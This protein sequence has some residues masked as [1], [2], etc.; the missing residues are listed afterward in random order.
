MKVVL[1]KLM[2]VIVAIVAF[3]IIAYF[4]YVLIGDNKIDPVLKSVSELDP[5]R[6]SSADRL[7]VLGIE[8][9]KDVGYYF[10][11]DESVTIKYGKHDFKILRK[12]I[13][14]EEVEGYLTALHLEIK[15]TQKGNILVYYKGAKVEKLVT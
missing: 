4:G 15:T 9:V 10:E 12:Y 5:I 6:N 1:D 7:G 8:S 11:D 13:K 3:V 2:I 14:D